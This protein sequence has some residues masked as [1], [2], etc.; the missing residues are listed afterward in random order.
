MALLGRVQ[1]SLGQ[2]YRRD[3]PQDQDGQDAQ[4]Y[5]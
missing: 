4:A 5:I 2:N 3:G 1:V